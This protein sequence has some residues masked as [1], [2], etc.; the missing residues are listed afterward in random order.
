M[1]K[2]ADLKK[3]DREKIEQEISAK[4][5]SLGFNS[6]ESC[7]AYS[8]TKD[9]GQCNDCKNLQLVKSEF[10]TILAKCCDFEII[11]H[12]GEPITE[13]TNYEQRNTITLNQMNDMAYIIDI[14][15]KE[16]GF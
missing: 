16:I 5:G 10:R 4:A 13:C 7:K 8:K 3:K 12:A 1:P 2:L 9:F 14:S 15:N 6:Y 11:L